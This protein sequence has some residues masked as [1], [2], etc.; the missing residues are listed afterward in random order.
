M[1]AERNPTRLGWPQITDTVAHLAGRIR[2]DG[3]PEV[4]VG[5]LRGGLIPA[6]LLAHHLGIR[7]V[8]AVEVV[9]TL[10]DHI[11]AAKTARPAVGNP[12]SLGE[13]TGRDVLLVDDIAGSGDTIGHTVEVVRA[14]GPARI[15]TAVCVVNAANWRRVQR[16]EQALTYLGATVEGWV[17]FP[18]E[19]Q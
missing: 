6:V 8:R 3:V 12:A 7:T 18:W 13:L 2:A 9:H 17:I 1:A 11:D 4:V 15:R 10:S 16:P 5:V 19:N 14:A